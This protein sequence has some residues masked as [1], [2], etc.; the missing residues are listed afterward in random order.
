MADIEGS[1][2]TRAWN[3][4]ED[5]KKCALS[6]RG[7]RRGMGISKHTGPVK[8]RSITV[9]SPEVAEVPNEARRED[10][11]QHHERGDEVKRL[12]QWNHCAVAVH[13]DPLSEKGSC[14]TPNQNN[15]RGDCAKIHHDDGRV[16]D[17]VS[18]LTKSASCERG[19]LKVFEHSDRATAS[20]LAKDRH[21][22][23]NRLRCTDEYNNSYPYCDACRWPN[24]I[25]KH[26][27]TASPD[28]QPHTT[29]TS[30]YAVN[31]MS[32]RK[33]EAI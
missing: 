33:V 22:Q 18:L 21:A 24:D 16:H 27:D 15:I 9:Y 10:Q 20:I 31:F 11:Q 8:S 4:R 32:P 14:Q 1:R 29:C 30:C 7:S 2:K 3:A 26:V 6:M 17:Q 28:K 12:P 23:W 5:K 25:A 13:L 19:E